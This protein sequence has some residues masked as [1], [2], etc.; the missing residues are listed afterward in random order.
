MKVYSV[1]NKICSCCVFTFETCGF[2]CEVRVD[3]ANIPIKHYLYFAVS[4]YRL[5][6]ILILF[7]RESLTPVFCAIQ[8]VKWYVSNSRVVNV[9]LQNG[10]DL[11]SM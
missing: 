9:Y 2:L 5:W 7:G 3:D 6:P 8:N 4:G 11:E 1:Y 10:H